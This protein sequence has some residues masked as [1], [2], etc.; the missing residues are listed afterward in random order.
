VTGLRTR[1]HLIC[2]FSVVEASKPFFI[3]K[4]RAVF[5][6]PGDELFVLYF[7]TFTCRLIRGLHA[8]ANLRLGV[9]V[10]LD[11]PTFVHFT[12]IIP[13]NLISA[14]R[15]CRTPTFVSMFL[16]KESGAV[17]SRLAFGSALFE[18]RFEITAVGLLFVGMELEWDKVGLA[19]AREIRF[20][21]VE[22]E[23]F[24]FTLGDE[25]FASRVA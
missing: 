5:I 20:S 15:R 14:V 13:A 22:C 19:V 12:L 7:Y 9:V 4:L 2:S 1:E 25:P 8:V 3:A 23:P 10:V 21:C 11:G 18:H 16:I 24:A 6:C 17:L